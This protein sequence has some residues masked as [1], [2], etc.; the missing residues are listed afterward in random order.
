[1][2]EIPKELR[3]EGQSWA[4][5][6]GGD[7]RMVLDCFIVLNDPELQATERMLATLIIF[8]EKFSDVE[9]IFQ[10][11]ESTQ[12]A[13]IDA[14]FNFF[15]CGEKVSPGI[16][17]PYKL[18]DWEQDAQMICAA[19]NTVAQK[20]IR[21]EP[22]MHWWTFMGYYMSVGESTL[23]TVL[24][25]RSKIIKGKKLEKHEQEFRRSNPQYFVWNKDS[26][27]KQESDQLARDLWNSGKGVD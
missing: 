16:Q 5:R 25:I 6:N 18:V 4:I 9:D 22:Y 23:S 24:G 21:S 27:N 14:M 11:P 26:V 12:E 3:V 10:L 17:T 7:F 1:M 13:L 8:Y 15:N 20:E 19:V 2:Y